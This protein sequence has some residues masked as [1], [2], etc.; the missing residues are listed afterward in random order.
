MNYPVVS[1]QDFLIKLDM[2]PCM[3]LVKISFFPLIHVMNKNILNIE[4][5][6]EAVHNFG[7]SDDDMI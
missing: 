7:K 3:H 4:M 6:E 5:F 1:V 2:K